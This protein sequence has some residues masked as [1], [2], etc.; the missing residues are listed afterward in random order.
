MRALVKYDRG[1][2]KLRIEDK[3]KPG[4]R[5]NEVLVKI[6]YCGV[7][8]T[9]LKIRADH[10]P[11]DPPVIIGHEFSGVVAE[12]GDKAGGWKPGDKVVAEQHFKACGLCEFCLTGRRRFCK[13]KRSPGYYS[14]GAFTEYIAVDASLLHRVPAEVDLVQASLTEPAAIA[15]TAILGKAGVCPGDFAVILGTGPISMLA[16]Q[17]VKTAGAAKVI[18]TGLD[19]DEAVRFQIARNF[20]A[21]AV[22]NVQ[23]ADPVAAA[24]ELTNEK[25]ADLV[26]DLSGAPSAIK[27][28]FRMLKKD[29]RFCAIGLPEAD[30]SLPWAEL[31]LGACTV[32]FSYSS[33]YLAWERVL[34]M[35]ADRRLKT[36]G[37]TENI[38]PMEKWETA[39]DASA[40]GEVLK[41]IIRMDV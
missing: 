31:V 29:G 21:D 5:A 14:D 24:Q 19:V 39:F 12:V 35:L 7:C 20:G 6:H 33:D 36:D 22:I 34:T 41:A 3:P 27:S 40:S 16:L 28:G 11:Y 13:H 15:A 4:I 17:M 26:I 18:T 1:L 2:G 32:F 9:D 37:F 38:F 23:K 10:F 30:V 25:G 8:G